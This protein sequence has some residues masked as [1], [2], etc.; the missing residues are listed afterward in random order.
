MQ[1]VPCFE[2]LDQIFDDIVSGKS[3]E[4]YAKGNLS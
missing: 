2:T 3:P 1:T 4:I